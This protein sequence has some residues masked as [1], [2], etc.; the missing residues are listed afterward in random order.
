MLEATKH[1]MSSRIKR[2]PNPKIASLV[3]NH[4]GEKNRMIDTETGL[5]AALVVGEIADEKNISWAL[6]GGIAM[7]LYGSPRLTKDVDLI[8]SDLLP[9][10]AEKKLNFGGQHY[11]V[12]V[13]DK[14]IPVAWIVRDDDALNYYKAALA[15]AVVIEGVRVLTPEWLVILKYIAGRFKDQEDAVFLLKKKELID[16]KK[17][18]KLIVSNGGREAWAVMAVGLQRWY[19]IADGIITTEKNEYEAERL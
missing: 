2:K 16:R 5:E 1:L 3:K 15:D 12:K 10:S 19:D 9:L 14:K 8:A 17:I 13:D 18:K 6:C 4:I 11:T 7:H